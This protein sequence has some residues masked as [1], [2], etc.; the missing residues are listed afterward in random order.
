MTST[1]SPKLPFSRV[2]VITL[3]LFMAAMVLEGVSRFIFIR[4]GLAPLVYA[5]KGLITLALLLS[6]LLAARA[7][8]I[9]K[10]FIIVIGLALWTLALGVLQVRAIVPV[11]FGV[12]AILPFFFGVA[13]YPYLRVHWRNL[14]SIVFILWGLAVMGIVLNNFVEF[15]W[16]GFEFQ[17]A[18]VNLVGSRAWATFDVSRLAGF[19][20][21]SIAA[22]SHITLLAL[23]LLAAGVRR[24]L[25]L[26]IIISSAVALYLTTMKTITGAFILLSLFVL[27][28]PYIARPVWVGLPTLAALIGFVLPFSTLMVSYNLTF[29]NPVNRFLFASFGIRLAEVWPQTLELVQTRGQPL[30]GRGIGGIGGAQQYFEPS[31]YTPG[32][33]LMLYLYVLGG[34]L[35]VVLLFGYALAAVK[36]E[37]TRQRFDAYIYTVMMTVLLQ[38]ITG[39]VMESAFFSLFFGLSLRHVMTLPLRQP[40]Q[41][42]ANV[43]GMPSQPQLGSA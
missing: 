6:V 21:V 28:R 39:N 32:D 24:W 10:A 22:A 27:L 43:L 12:W 35:F 33:N 41:E 16:A 38:G 9:N 15:P 30:L 29:E 42:S 18:G 14:R 4:A 7:A 5:P 1:A 37:P 40:Q 26:I 3:V 13:I 2:Y 36:L 25:A 34:V 11:L 20:R 8:H 23:W 19:S 31:R 17:L